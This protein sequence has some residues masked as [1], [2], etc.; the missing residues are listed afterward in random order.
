MFLNKT[1]FV[2]G[3]TGVVG[4]E[5]TKLLLKKRIFEK[6]VLIGRR[7]IDLGVDNSTCAPYEQIQVDF[8]KIEE[9]KSAF[10][11]SSVGF[12]CLGS[13]YVGVTKENFYK[14]DHDYI[15]NVARIAKESGCEQFHLV[16]SNGANKNSFL[17]GLK[18]KGITEED[19]TNLTFRRL[20]IYRPGQILSKREEFRLG[21]RIA[22][23]VLKPIVWLFPTLLTVPVDLVAKSMIVNL[24]NEIKNENGVEII[25]N[26]TIH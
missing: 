22:L 1:A 7:Q 2:V 16:T 3:Y 6:V 14:V 4:K 21:E 23:I 12:C 9:Y 8:D 10:H 25:D 26:K 15:L 20:L 17:Y 24:W 19:V 11:G 13:K 18:V 5:L